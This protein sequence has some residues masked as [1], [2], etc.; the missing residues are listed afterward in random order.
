MLA[1]RGYEMAVAQ[2]YPGS[3]TSI[4]ERSD[5]D[6]R[7][8][9]ICVGDIT[10]EQAAA[11]ASDSRY[12][13][14]ADFSLKGAKHTVT[15]ENL[16]ELFNSTA[17]KPGDRLV[18]RGEYAAP[19]DVNSPYPASRPYPGKVV[20]SLIGTPDNPIIIDARR[21]TFDGVI[22]MLATGNAVRLMGLDA[23]FRHWTTR[24]ADL[25]YPPQNLPSYA[26]GNGGLRL[27]MPNAQLVNCLIH[28]F[29]IGVGSWLSAWN[30]LTYGCLL[31]HNGWY[32]P[33]SGGHDHGEGMYTQN[34][35]GTKTVRHCAGWNNYDHNLAIY[36]T[37]AKTDHFRVEECIFFSDGTQIGGA[38][39]FDDMGIQGNFF[40]SEGV[41]LGFTPTGINPSIQVVNNI[42]ATPPDWFRNLMI[43]SR[44]AKLDFQN[45]IVI[46]NENSHPVTVYYPPN[47]WSDWTWDYNTYYYTERT[48][49]LPG[50]PFQ[51][52]TAPG[53]FTDLTFEQW[54]AYTG[55]DQ[56][57]RMI[58]GKP[59]DYSKMMLNEYEERR[60]HVVIYNW[61][62]ANAHSVDLTGLPA[63]D[64]RASSMQNLTESFN[65][66]Y[67]GNGA[68]PFRMTG[69]T[70]GKPMG[71]QLIP[72]WPFPY[73]NTYPEFGAFL[74]T[75]R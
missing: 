13:P 3:W 29:R 69:W 49:D 46:G 58:Y 27:H 14:A 44:F 33:E 63:G 60:A 55:F 72:S 24:M 9:T 16:I 37:T 10:T 30:A 35:T 56:H 38:V 31:Y 70:V 73:Q 19:N 41:W 7:G 6:P 32:S 45:N 61:T 65:F 26:S 34:Q 66:S 50:Q 21:A 5:P 11:L 74:I 2:D 43:Y 15:P 51:I 8:L 75:A 42:F 22:E 1:G 17:I 20:C 48:P 64:Y 67:S 39:A 52:Q 12:P 25:T 53:V 62:R 54:Q 59:P 40:Y 68:Q 18:M 47:R 4:D 28:D 57:S 23:A 36:G 71:W